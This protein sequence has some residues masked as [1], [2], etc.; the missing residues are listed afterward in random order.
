M[1]LGDERLTTTDK[2]GKRI[3][4]YPAEV[5]GF[6]RKYRTIT[7]A[8]LIIFF[9]ILPWITI[10]GQQLLLLDFGNKSFHFF[11]LIFKAHDA[12]MIFLV[13]A[14][15][16][17]GIA[18][19]TAL[20]GRV[21]CGWAC[22]QT[23]F[24]DGVYRK[25]EVW[26]QGN[27][28][29]RRKLAKE[30]WT[31]NKFSK[32]SLT[33]IAYF[34]VSTLVAHSFVSYFVGSQRLLEMMQGTPQENWSAFLIVMGMTGVLMFDFGWF[35]EQ[36]C[37]IAC[38]YGRFQAALMDKK[39]VSVVYDYNRGEPRKESSIPKD[40]Q[41]DCVNCRRCVEV[42][43]TGIDIRRGIQMECIGCTA[44]IDAC[45]E[46]MEKVN[47]PVGLIRYGS[48]YE[49]ESKIKP[50]WKSLITRPRVVLYSVIVFAVTGWLILLLQS[51]EPLMVSVLKTKNT[52]YTILVE[53]SKSYALNHFKLHVHNQSADDVNIYI[54]AGEDIELVIPQNNIVLKSNSS[55]DI[56][57]FAKFEERLSKENHGSLNRKLNIETKTNR[58][59]RKL[60]K[61]LTLVGPI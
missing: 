10:D 5:R 25:I 34:I 59:V 27:Y 19:V 42:C 24:I 60:T 35:R 54:T 43:P 31:F 8:I 16:S 46:I 21:W 37:I 50:S 6:F 1:S 23:V 15:I 11:G 55:R 53:N 9:L 22:P 26:I 20:L 57:F 58:E 61:D 4:L 48:E 49:L 45:D 51:R 38:P 30:G 56:Y 13:L 2:T 39:S 14:G 32:V 40:Q 29:Q 3:F 41:G 36:F 12:P 18:L 7:Q 17:I 44:C 47:K 52:P 28:I 33:W